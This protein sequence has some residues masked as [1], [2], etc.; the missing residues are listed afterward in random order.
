MNADMMCDYI[1]FCADRAMTDLG[2]AKIYNKAN[3]FPWMELIGL[4]G[5][6]NFFERL[7]SNYA[8]AGVMA[9]ASEQ[10]FG[11]DGDF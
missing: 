5:K 2:Y 7:E 8:R 1:K 10:V 4:T 6:S 11:T 9:D 3:P